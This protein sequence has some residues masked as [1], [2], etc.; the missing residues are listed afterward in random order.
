MSARTRGPVE[1]AI[2]LSP[3]ILSEAKDPGSC[4]WFSDSQPTAEILRG[5]YSARTTE[6]L[7]FAQNDKRRTQDDKFPIS[8]HLRWQSDGLPILRE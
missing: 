5:V 8:S 4:L 7:R 3:V 6:I 2:K 1:P